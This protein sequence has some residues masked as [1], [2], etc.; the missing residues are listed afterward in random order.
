M[1]EV[2]VCVHRSFPW[3]IFRPQ[4]VLF[5]MP[6]IGF[7]F[8]YFL[9]LIVYLFIYYF[10]MFIYLLFIFRIWF[11]YLLWFREQYK[12]SYFNLLCLGISLNLSHTS[13]E[14]RPSSKSISE[15]SCLFRDTMIAIFTSHTHKLIH[16]MIT[17]TLVYV[18]LGIW[19]FGTVWCWI[20][21]LVNYWDW[22]GVISDHNNCVRSAGILCCP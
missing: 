11:C 21:P 16:I 10:W 9:Y 3:S 8:I 4:N 22:Q 7:S 12:F 17:L 19:Q 1:S 14:N 18:I 20:N 5:K 6:H 13:L 15:P 2:I